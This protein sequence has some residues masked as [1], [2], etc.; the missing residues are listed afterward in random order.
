MSWGSE[1]VKRMPGRGTRKAQGSE[2]TFPRFAATLRVQF[3]HAIPVELRSSELTAGEIVDRPMSV[4][5]IA[6]AA[7][8]SGLGRPG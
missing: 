5:S 3:V 6:C 4:P 1:A 8:R 2:M 7:A